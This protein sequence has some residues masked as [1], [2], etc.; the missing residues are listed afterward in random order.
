MYKLSSY[1]YTHAKKELPYFSANKSSEEIHEIL[2]NA[3]LNPD[4]D[5]IELVDDLPN[6]YDG[7]EEMV[8]GEDEVLE[9]DN[10]LNLEG[11]VNTLG[12]LIEDSLEKGNEKG[13]IKEI[14]I[15][16]SE[17]NDDIEWDPAEEANKIIDNM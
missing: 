7:A 15:E 9:I 3:H 1:Y 13:S 11:F 10:I 8:I 17:N 2:I 16:E 4:D 6:Y 5:L 14:L 12:D